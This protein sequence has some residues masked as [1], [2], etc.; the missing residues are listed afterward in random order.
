[1][2]KHPLHKIL[3]IDIETVGISSNFENFQRDYPALSYQFENYLDWFHKR[4]PEDS[5]KPKEEVFV[6]RAA[7]V[8]EFLKIVCVSVG[9]VLVSARAAAPSLRTEAR[10]LTAFAAQAR[11]S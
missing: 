2:I 6:N 8:P 5:E 7:L 3:F 9:F 10:P 11:A 4:F 1:M